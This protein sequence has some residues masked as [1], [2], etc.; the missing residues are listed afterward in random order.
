MMNIP[1]EKTLIAEI[2]KR[3]RLLDEKVALIPN[4]DTEESRI[5]STVMEYEKL[6]LVEMHGMAM[7]FARHGTQEFVNGLTPIN[8]INGLP[9][10]I[11]DKVKKHDGI[12]GDR[13]GMLEWDG[14]RK[15]FFL[16]TAD[17]GSIQIGPSNLER[18]E[19]L[20]D[21]DVDTTK[22]ECRQRPNK[23]KW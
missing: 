7:W 1:T 5:I 17:G 4:K 6:L 20:F 10:C 11:G 16:R 15:Q 18:I 9:L 8:D 3:I 2:Q 12:S 13:C 23:K 19:E 21:F 22:T 14:Y